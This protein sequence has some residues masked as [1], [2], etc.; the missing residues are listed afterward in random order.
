MELTVVA[1]KVGE[2]T[3]RGFE[4]KFR[5][6]AKGLRLGN[7][8]CHRVYCDRSLEKLYYEKP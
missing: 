1:S 5:E 6:I 4:F 8:N 2:S 7:M 3:V